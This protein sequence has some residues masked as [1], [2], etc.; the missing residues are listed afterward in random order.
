MVMVDHIAQETAPVRTGLRGLDP[1]SLAAIV[2]A[3]LVLLPVVS[4]LWIALRG[5][6]A[7]IWPHLLSTTLPRYVTNTVI[8]MIGVGALTSAVGVGA[9]WLVTM[10]RFPGRNWLQWA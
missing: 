8:L 3:I 10:Y 5:G 6:G 4:V 7:D 2:I 9:A 1:W